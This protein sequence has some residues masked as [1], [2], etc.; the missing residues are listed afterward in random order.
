M[1]PLFSFFAFPRERGFRSCVCH[2]RPKRA[3]SRNLSKFKQ[4]IAPCQV[5]E[6]GIL[7]FGIRNT[8]QTRNPE[9][10]GRL[11]SRIQVLLTK[12]GIQCLESGIHGLESRIQ[13]CP[14]FPYMGR[15]VVIDLRVRNGWYSSV[16]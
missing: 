11:E 13:D 12:T 8:A 14:G 16:L 10:H 7:G 5:R 6:S 9:S 1:T 3:V 15:S 4:C 2:S